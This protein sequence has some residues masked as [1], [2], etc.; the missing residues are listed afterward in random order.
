MAINIKIK[1]LDNLISAIPEELLYRPPKEKKSSE[2]LRKI[3]ETHIQDLE[4]DIKSKIAVLEY[5]KLFLKQDDFNVC[6]NINEE[7][8]SF[9]E[10]FIRSIIENPDFIHLI[11]DK[12][13]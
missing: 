10:V 13:K 3:F 8:E 12:N 5:L 11:L 4:D 1:K 7:A 6:E 9:C 2:S